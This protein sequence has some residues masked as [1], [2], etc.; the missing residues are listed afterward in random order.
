VTVVTED[1]RVLAVVLDVEA[2]RAR[3]RRLVDEILRAAQTDL[4]AVGKLMAEMGCRHGCRRGCRGTSAARS[5]CRTCPPP[6]VREQRN[7]CS[8]SD[9]LKGGGTG[10]S[11]SSCRSRSMCAWTC[12]TLTSRRWSPTAGGSTAGGSAGPCGWG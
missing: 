2:A 6:H 12:R 11:A 1:R 9:G 8:P 10:P 3:Q 4:A 5:C 7:R